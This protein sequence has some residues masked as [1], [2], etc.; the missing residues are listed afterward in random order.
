M[1][2]QKSYQKYAHPTERRSH[3]EGAVMFQHAPDLVAEEKEVA[4]VDE[5]EQPKQQVQV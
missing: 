2:R 1:A 4:V 3:R 5:Q